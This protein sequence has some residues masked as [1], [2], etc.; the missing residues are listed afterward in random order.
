MWCVLLG[1]AAVLCA[2]GWFI[3]FVSCAALLWY[4]NEK[5]IPAPSE[6]EMK[7]GCSWALSHILS[8]AL[9]R[10]NRR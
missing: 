2:G 4:L 6:E 10:K 8:D 7:R 9:C 5:G 1:L 3:R